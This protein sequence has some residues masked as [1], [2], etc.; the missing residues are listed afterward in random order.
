V[1]IL[2]ISKKIHTF[3]LYEHLILFY[4]ISENK[5][6]FQNNVRKLNIYK[7]KTK[8]N[9]LFRVIFAIQK[10]SQKEDISMFLKRSGEDGLRLNGL[11]IMESVLYFV[12]LYIILSNKII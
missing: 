7:I 2:N 11:T 6:L 1:K 10:S 5:F 4:G 8:N 12:I 3:I 9:L